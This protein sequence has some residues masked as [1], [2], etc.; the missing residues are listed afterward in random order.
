MI[1][2]LLQQTLGV[3]LLLLSGCDVARN[4]QRDLA[5]LTSSDPFVAPR[6]ARPSTGIAKPAPAADK[7]D[8]KSD[9]KTA[10]AP[11]GPENAAANESINLAGKSESDLIALLGPPNSE[12]SRAPGKTWHYREGQCTV[13]IRLYP[14]VQ[15]RQFGSLG[16]EVKSDDNTDEGRRVCLAQ[17]QS[18]TRGK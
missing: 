1:K 10:S 16:Y 18:R 12:E 3:V 17:L 5:R 4:A 8:P 6:P 14:D 11:S 7:T 2:S 13:D 15:T 9:P